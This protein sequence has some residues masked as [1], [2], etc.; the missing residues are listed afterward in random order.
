MAH[1]NDVPRLGGRPNEVV[2]L[3]LRTDE[4]RNVGGARGGDQVVVVVG[5]FHLLAF[6]VGVGPRT[7]PCEKKSVHSLFGR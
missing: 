4:P 2:R 1:S 3:A 6:G 7:V 5:V